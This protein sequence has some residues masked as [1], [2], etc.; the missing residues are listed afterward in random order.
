MHQSLEFTSIEGLQFISEEMKYTERNIFEIK[1]NSGLII[2]TKIKENYAFAKCNVD[3][4]PQYTNKIL[5]QKALEK[6]K[7][8]QLE[9][10][11]QI[12]PDFLQYS[13][14]FGN[15][16]ACVYANNHESITFR[17]FVKFNNLQNLRFS[18]TDQDKGC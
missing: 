1:P 16:Y 3:V 12:Y 13:G 7:V 15:Q 2:I 18:E 4:Q 8:K 11:G 6:G 9:V 5:L 10:E 14:F 17:V